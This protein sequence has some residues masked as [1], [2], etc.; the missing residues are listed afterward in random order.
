MHRLNLTELND[1]L[2]KAANTSI[3]TQGHL[4][5]GLHWSTEKITCYG[6][7]IIKR[8]FISCLLFWKPKSFKTEEA[9][10]C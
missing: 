7:E 10:V 8:N 5:Y 2:L 6:N 4:I 3:N 9:A 1:E